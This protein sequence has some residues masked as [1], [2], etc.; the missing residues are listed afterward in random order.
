MMSSPVSGD[1]GVTSEEVSA[2]Q[3]GRNDP[4]HEDGVA[5]CRD[6]IRPPW[7]GLGDLGYSSELSE[8]AP[9]VECSDDCTEP[10]VLTRSSPPIPNCLTTSEISKASDDHRCRDPHICLNMWSVSGGLNG[11]TS[12]LSQTSPGTCGFYINGLMKCARFVRFAIA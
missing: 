10:T 5:H 9:V 1:Q 7:T 4:Q 8:Q 2:E 11:Y 3:L 6:T 12:G